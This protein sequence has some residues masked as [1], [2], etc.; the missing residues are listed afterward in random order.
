MILVDAN[1]L[2][3]AIDRDSPHHAKA[4]RWLEQTL[5]GDTWVG[6]PWIVILAFIRLT[7]R[8][9]IVR[10]P[11]RPEQAF[12]FVDA[13]LRQPYVTALAPGEHHWPI[14]RNLLEANGTAGNLT[15]DAHV[16]ALALEY[17]CT[18]VSA[19][20]DFRRFSGVIHSNP[21]SD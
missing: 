3:Y 15:S 13:W 19:D 5:S 11:L 4:R 17:G 2:I 6:L 10:S 7:T 20:S 12:A 21:L 1:M 8:S 16:A 14:L 9:G 18:V